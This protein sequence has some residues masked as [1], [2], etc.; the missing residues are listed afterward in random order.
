MKNPVASGAA[1]ESG[2]SRDAAAKK[3]VGRPFTLIELLVVIA[4]IAIL[5]AILLPALKNARE[6]GKQANCQVN[7]K[8]LGNA[9]QMYAS[10]NDDTIAYHYASGSVPLWFVVLYT[11]HKSAMLYNCPSDQL[12][13]YKMTSVGAP[14]TV[15]RLP[16]GLPGGLS[17]LMNNCASHTAK[18]GKCPYPAKQ[19]IFADGSGHWVAG[20]FGVNAQNTKPYEWKLRGDRNSDV[21]FHL[22]HARHNG[23]WNISYLGGNAG[24]LSVTEIEELNPNYKSAASAMT[25]AGRIFYFGTS[26]GKPY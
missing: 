4:I 19:M 8:Q 24:S 5:A 9:H 26:D 10:D 16:Q 7:C 25:E 13:G 6:R 11:Y 21:P 1:C 18:I 15:N 3:N 17:Y 22:W 20:V 14:G 2:T 23:K 12:Q